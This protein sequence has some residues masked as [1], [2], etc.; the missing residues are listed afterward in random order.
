MNRRL[1]ITADDY[2]MCEPVNQAIEEC[3]A[4]GTV[5]ATCVMTNMPAYRTTE[6][7]RVKFPQSSLG[8]HWTLTEGRP[9]LSPAQIPSLVRP[10]GT[11]YSAGQLRQRWRQRR[12]K[13]TEINTEL[14]AQYQRFCTLADQPDFWNT[15]QNFHVFPGLFEVCVALGQ[16]LHIPAMRCHRR[17][18]V[19]RTQAPLSYHMRH[20]L[21]WFKG[22][23]ISWWAYR[24]KRQGMLMP[25]GVVHIP[26][27]E[28]H[29]T[30]IAEAV[31]H[32]PWDT[33]P[34]AV[35]LIIHPAITSQEA[36]FHMHPERRV[37][38]YRVFTAQQLA[39][40]LD[41][42]GVKTVGFEVLHNSSHSRS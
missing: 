15:H 24:A 8:I 13:A 11:F 32:L 42:L 10:D 41:Q 2:G 14:R 3:L 22:K 9:V 34:H 12:V 26:D 37:L 40:R 21:P 27:Y 16:E 35:E 31:T 4:V 6:S 39:K 19:P 30:V 23:V 1:I 28:A 18:T 25:D 17:F 36:L 29:H 7:L 38:E 20:P 33:V 5:R